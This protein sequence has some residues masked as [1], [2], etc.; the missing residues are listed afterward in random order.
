MGTAGFPGSEAHSV[1]HYQVRVP[2]GRVISLLN[3]SFSSGPL[4]TDPEHTDTEHCKPGF[5]SVQVFYTVVY[6]VRILILVIFVRRTLSKYEEN[7]TFKYE[8]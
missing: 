1:E 7:K 8:T 5:P 3:S 4:K 2:V 6:C